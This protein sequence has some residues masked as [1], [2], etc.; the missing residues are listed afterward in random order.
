[1]TWRACYHE[2]VGRLDD[3]VARNRN[4]KRSER[5]TVGIG[6]ALFLLLIIFL[7]TFTDLGLPSTDSP[8]PANKVEKR[9]NDVQL[10]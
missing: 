7:M 9:V 1:M 6:L 8:P 4:P 5:M 2:A 3:I 10:R